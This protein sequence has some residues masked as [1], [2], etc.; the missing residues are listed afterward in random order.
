MA[1]ISLVVKQQ[2]LD[3]IRQ[4]YVEIQKNKKWK[5][6]SWEEKYKLYK[7]YKGKTRYYNRCKIC[8]RVHWY[9]RELWLCRV[10][11]RMYGRSWTLMWVRKSSW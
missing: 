7:K 3:K 6:L 10:C 1:K 5:N 9:N 4:K 8:W 2:K 11:I